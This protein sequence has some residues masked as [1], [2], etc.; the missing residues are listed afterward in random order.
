[1][2]F[3]CWHRGRAAEADGQREQGQGQQLGR[4]LVC[5]RCRWLALQG[6]QGQA[7]PQLAAVAAVCMS[8]QEAQQ[9]ASPP[10]GCR[11]RGGH[12]VS[13][14]LQQSKSREGSAAVQPQWALQA[15]SKADWRLSK[16]V[17]WVA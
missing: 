7:W 15:R 14:P 17:G 12:S 13:P 10:E 4:H 11:G 16:V 3:C 5:M 2:Q 1:M 6:G 8:Q 9:S